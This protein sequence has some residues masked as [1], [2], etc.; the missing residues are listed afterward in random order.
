[1]T[2]I[3]GRGTASNPALRY[4]PTR[5]ES[6][7]DGWWQEEAEPAAATQVS[8]EQAKSLI[9][10]NDSPDLPFSQAL[11][12]YRGCEH[13]CIYC[14]ARP[15]HAYWDLSPGL[16]FETRLIAKS[17]AAEVLRHE[18]SKPGYRPSAFSL[19]SNTDPYQPIE[20]D[21]RITR[22]ILELLHEHRHPVSI[23]TKG[24]LVMRDLD[25]LENMAREGLCSVMI[26]LTTLDTDLKNTLEPRASAPSRRLRI[27]RELSS[28]G[29]PCGVLV[30]PVI[31]A[32]NEHELEHIL[33]AAAEAGAQSAASMA[34]RLPQ[35]VAELFREWLN[36]HYPLKA[37]HVMSRI[38][39]MRGGR[40]NDTRFGQRMTGEGEFA[41]LLQQRFRLACRR[42]GLKAAG[43]GDLCSEN[44]HPPERHGQYRLF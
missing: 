14:Y 11:N 22:Q 19:G 39:A 31:P 2:P 7:D 42:L 34:I 8:F 36:A 12:P 20:R 29:I 5:V 27:L 40:D 4:A 44:F 21:L 43:M 30:S 3:K 33:E 35:E 41:Q 9:S 24:S 32:L 25:I 6:V 28:R 18:L 38:Q 15:S 1:M 17:N 26:S 37:K 23:V 13:G 16:D 10:R